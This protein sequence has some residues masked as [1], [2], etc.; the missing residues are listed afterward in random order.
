M[1]IIGRHNIQGHTDQV[2]FQMMEDFSC[3]LIE[4]SCKEYS[5]FLK[6][7]ASYDVE[8]HGTKDVRSTYVHPFNSAIKERI[9]LFSLELCPQDG[10]FDFSVPIDTFINDPVKIFDDAIETLQD[11]PLIE[12]GILK[13]MFMGKPKFLKVVTPDSDFAKSV[14]PIEQIPIL[15]LL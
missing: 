9:P 5:R 2:C 7:A 3:Q 12:T 1:Y 11:I 4:E 15:Y 10:A 14:S 6:I 13:R 8:I